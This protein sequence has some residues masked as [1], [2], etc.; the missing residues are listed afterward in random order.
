MKPLSSTH[1]QNVYVLR[2]LF[3]RSMLWLHTELVIKFFG[4]YWVTLIPQDPTQKVCIRSWKCIKYKCINCA[5]YNNYCQ[6]YCKP[7]GKIHWLLQIHTPISPSYMNEPAGLGPVWMVHNA[8]KVLLT[9]TLGAS[10]VPGI[11]CQCNVN[12]TTTC[13]Y[14]P[15]MRSEQWKQKA[16]KTGNSVEKRLSSS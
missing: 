15:D 8:W 16:G 6:D 2:Q 9:A 3:L 4:F 11:R 13:M 12:H 7:I 1:T 5:A 14:G 10:L